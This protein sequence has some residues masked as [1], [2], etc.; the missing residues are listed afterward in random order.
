MKNM[1]IYKHTWYSNHISFLPI[2]AQQTTQMQGWVKTDLRMSPY[3]NTC[4]GSTSISPKYLDHPYLCGTSG[5]PA[6]L[7]ASKN[8]WT[9]LPSSFSNAL[10]KSHEISVNPA[11]LKD[12]AL[13]THLFLPTWREAAP[14]QP[15]GAAELWPSMHTPSL[16]GKPGVSPGISRRSGAASAASTISKFLVRNWVNSYKFMLNVHIYI[17]TYEYCSVHV[18]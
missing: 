11:I 10:G 3:L 17:Y 5:V 16:P 2:P 1:Q 12:D 9:C 18:E 15:E 7:R 4:G 6:I 8:L 13:I 14:Q